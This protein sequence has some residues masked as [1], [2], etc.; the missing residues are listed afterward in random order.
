MVKGQLEIIATFSKDIGMKFG[1]DVCAFLHVEKGII[2]KSL[3]LNINHLAI[4][5]VADGDS[6]KYL[7][8]DE[9][10]TYNGPLNK[11]KVSKEYLNRVQGVW[12]S[13][14]S[15]SN[16]VIAHSSFAVPIITTT[17][18][19]IDWAIDEIRQIDINTRKLLTMTGSFHPSSDVDRICMTRVKGGR[20][21]RSIR[22]L[23]ES[24]IISL[25]Q[26]L[27]RN[28]NRNEILE[29][30]SEC[31]QAYIIRV[32]N[33]LLINNDITET[34]DAKMKSIMRKYTKVKAKEHEQQYINKKMHW[35]YH[36]RLQQNYS[37]DISASQQRSHKKQIR[38]QF[39][40]YL[41]AVQD[42][43]IATT[44]LVHKRQIDSGQS[45]TAN[46]KCCLCKL[47]IEDVSHISSCSKMS[48]QYYLPLHHDALAI[49]IL[50]A[51]ITKNHHNER[52][53]DLNNRSLSKS[54]SQSVRN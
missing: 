29:Y 44:F 10:I 17:I 24:R 21:L 19:I 27:L 50:K 53:H 6:Y 47:S 49:Y 5:P 30:V 51:I 12:S 3:P 48:T 22:T 18:G 54:V 4:Q 41:G 26:H 15:D 13:E 31:E 46:N 1:E 40:D 7:G 38:S 43:E 9:N 37:I 20:G 2:K 36:R 32:G 42:Q 34:P 35:Y 33:Q 39:E 25:Q 11:E 28:T 45:P 14:L 52:Y 8:I 16:K 23:Y